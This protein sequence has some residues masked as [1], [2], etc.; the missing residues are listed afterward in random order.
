MLKTKRLV[1]RAWLDSDAKNL[2]KYAKDLRVGPVTGW[3]PHKNVAESRQIIKDILQVDETYALC[4][5][6][7]NLAIGNISIMQGKRSRFNL[8]EDEAE[9]G[10]WLGVEFWGKG[11]MTEAVRE[12]LRHGFEDFDL[13]KI[14]CGYFDGNYRSKRVQEKCGFKYHHTDKN[15]YWETLG[16]YK[17][18]CVT[19]LDYDEWKRDRV[20]RL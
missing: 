4:L 16:E 1:L 19:F 3:K 12:I 9:V 5:K 2:Y 17:D 8:P 15:V 20:G 11:L 13:K 18:C 7:D 6:E 10:Y 14:W